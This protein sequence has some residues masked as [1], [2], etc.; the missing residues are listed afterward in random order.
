MNNNIRRKKNLVIERLN[1]RLLGESEMD[2]PKAT[3]DLELNTKNRDS[4]IKSGHIKYG[5]LNVSSGYR[6]QNLTVLFL[7]VCDPQ[8]SFLF[9]QNLLWIRC[10][11]S[12]AKS[13]NV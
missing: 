13:L 10:N 4:S 5:P 6:I 12:R 1:R 7:C 8:W 3:Q 9:S 2:C 11:Y